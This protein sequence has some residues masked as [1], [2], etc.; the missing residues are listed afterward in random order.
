MRFLPIPTFAGLAPSRRM[1]YSQVCHAL[2]IKLDHD[3][4]PQLGQRRLRPFAGPRW[5]R[6]VRRKVVLQGAGLIQIN[7][8]S[9]AT[10]KGWPSTAQAGS[11]PAMVLIGD[12]Y[13]F[14]RGVAQDYAKAMRW[15][16]K[17][18]DQGNAL[19]QANIGYL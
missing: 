11:P 5:N 4:D 2:S 18:A 15:Y 1:R 8:N 9:A 12:L 13:Y 16:R 10:M 14:G 6:K 17:A 19:A 3:P 7:A